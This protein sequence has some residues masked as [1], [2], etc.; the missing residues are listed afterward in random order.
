MPG[1]PP[2]A[3]AAVSRG[4]ARVGVHPHLVRF[5]VG[6]D[7]RI[8]LPLS[9]VCG[10]AFVVVCDLLSRVLFAPYEVPVGILMAFLGGPFFIYLILKNR[11]GSL[12]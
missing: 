6:H 1:P 12:D 3:G 5:F 7:N 9:A 10:A 8:V 11:R 4:P 2:L